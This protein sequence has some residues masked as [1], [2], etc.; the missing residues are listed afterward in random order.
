MKMLSYLPTAMLELKPAWAEELGRGH[1]RAQLYANHSERHSQRLG[2]RPSN[3]HLRLV[4]ME[5]WFIRP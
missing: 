1:A 4:Y 5:L 2:L 3:H